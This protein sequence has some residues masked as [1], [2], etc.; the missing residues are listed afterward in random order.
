M[1]YIE[2]KWKEYVK[3]MICCGI[4]DPRVWAATGGSE[5]LNLNLSNFGINDT[6][7][8]LRLVPLFK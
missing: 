4:N 8:E 6:R 1:Y 3:R 7:L 5:I 2:G